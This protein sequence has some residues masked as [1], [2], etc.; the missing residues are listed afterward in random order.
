M[1]EIIWTSTAINDLDSIAEYIEIDS[2]IAAKKFTREI[3]SKVDGLSN[4]PFRGR[5]IPEKIPG[6]YRQ[7]LHKSHRIIY[8]IED[9]KIYVSSIYHQ[10]KLLLKL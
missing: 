10:K 1:A 3:I 2:F 4:H 8:R 7:I 5:P 6:G 9:L